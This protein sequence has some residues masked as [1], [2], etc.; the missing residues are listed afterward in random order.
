[1]KQYSEKYLIQRRDEKR[2]YC[3]NCT[4]FYGHTFDGT[5]FGRFPDP[6]NDWTNDAEQ[7][8]KFDDRKQAEY[9]ME[10]V[11]FLHDIHCRDCDVI[12][13]K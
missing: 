13:M 9:F 2:F 8:W 7:A 1:M 6:D 5:P 4:G 12:E 10:R 3:L 11:E